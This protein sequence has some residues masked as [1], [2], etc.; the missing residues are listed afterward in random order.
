MK[1]WL[2]SMN[3]KRHQ[4]EINRLVRA[5]NKN[6][7]QDD[8]W[9]GRFVVRQVESPQ[10]V[11]YDDCSGRELWVTLKFIDRCTGRYFV[12]CKSVNHWRIFNGVNLWREMNDFIVE[13]CKVWNEDLAQTNR[14]AW[15]DFNKNVRVI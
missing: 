9:S 2:T 7:E 11:R 8:L 15:R 6:I 13:R 3:S 14:A 10:W 5:I 4:R 1:H 12:R